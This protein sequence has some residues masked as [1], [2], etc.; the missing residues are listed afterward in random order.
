MSSEFLSSCG[1]DHCC[2][3]Y[4]ALDDPNCEMIPGTECVSLL[5]EGVGWDIGP[6]ICA[7]PGS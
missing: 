6:G 4:C 7:D 1:G 3:P 5:E 2:T